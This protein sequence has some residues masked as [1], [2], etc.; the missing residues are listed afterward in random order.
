MA[1][2]NTAVGE[3]TFLVQRLIGLGHNE[4]VLHIGGHIDHLIGDHTGLFIHLTVRCLNEAVLIQ[5]AIAGQIRDQADVGSFGS[6]NG[7][8]SAVMGIV[9]ISHLKP[10]AVT[11]QTAGAQCG[12][13]ALMSQLR[14]GVVLVHKLGQRR[15]AEETHEW[16]PPPGEC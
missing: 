4:L 1:A 7:A 16:Q 13:T 10:G 5:P 2:G 15:G 11:G 14:Q 6:L 3:A 12:Q 9:Y 8:H